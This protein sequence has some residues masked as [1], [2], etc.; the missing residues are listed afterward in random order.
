MVERQEIA[1]SRHRG[2]GRYINAELSL[3]DFHLRVL[4]QAVDLA[5]PLLERLNFLIIFARNLDEFFEVHVAR[6]LPQ[7][8]KITDPPA[9][10]IIDTAVLNQIFNTTHAAVSHQYDILNQQ[11]LPLLAHHHIHILSQKELSPEQAIW[12]ENYFIQQVLPQLQPVFFDGTTDKRTKYFSNLTNK[13]LHVFITG[14]VNASASVAPSTAWAVVSVPSTL[15]QFILLPNAKHVPA[16]A[17]QYIPLTTLIQ[18]YITELLVGWQVTDCGVF[19]VTYQAYQNHGTILPDSGLTDL[20]L[21]N[22]DLVDLDVAAWQ[23]RQAVRLEIEQGCPT[24]MTQYLLQALRLS[25]AQLYTINGI[26]D[27]TQLT[28]LYQPPVLKEQALQNQLL[29]KVPLKYAAFTPYLSPALEACQNI[30]A[31]IKRQDILLHHP[32]DSFEPVIHLLRAAAHDPQVIAI[33]QTLYRSGRNSQIVQ[34]LIHAAKNGKQVTVIVELRVRQDEKNNIQ[35]VKALQHAGVQVIAIN[36]GNKVHAKILFI[37]RR[38]QQQLVSYVHLGTGNYHAVNARLYTDYGL[39]SADTALSKDVAQIF[40]YLINGNP[41]RSLKK[42][43]LAPA[44]LHST[45]L[46]FIAHEIKQAQAGQPAHII[47]KANALAEPQLI[48]ALYTAS[49]HGVKVD[50]IIRSICCLRPQVAGL[51]DNIRVRSIVGQF[52]EHTRVFYF[53]NAGGEP[54]VYCASADW[55]A[56]NMFSRI[57]VCF[58]IENLELKQRIIQQGLFNYLQ[59]N[60][61]AWAL[62]GS[63][64]WQRINPT[65]GEPPHTAQQLLLDTF[66]T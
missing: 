49:Q 40:A 60:Q 61:Q 32:F 12:A 48:D 38:E 17:M 59:D 65:K 46:D 43:L 2:D 15:A 8:N 29:E 31:Q 37:T 33:K 63:G 10:T 50:L 18:A 41:I 62:D 21:A 11:I 19:R 14:Q 54:R 64:M 66:N 56:R 47:I 27:L 35:I 6:L 52:L 34:Q 36:T 39:L 30:F 44:N 24:A 5:H 42:L 7:C 4:A 26:I 23:P 25:E 53:L 55:M 3:L 13:A 1:H 16:I 22:S 20:N 51:S 57:E 9:D 45:L 58:P 28:T